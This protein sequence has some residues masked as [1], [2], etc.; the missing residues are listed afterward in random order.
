MGAGQA[1]EGLFRF[2]AIFC[3]H[4][5][6]DT[7]YKMRKHLLFCNSFQSV[8]GCQTSRASVSTTRRAI[9][10]APRL[11]AGGGQRLLRG[12]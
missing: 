1:A 11:A 3:V 8:F 12:G 9:M 6:T 5:W 10:S 2:L 7:Q 4:K